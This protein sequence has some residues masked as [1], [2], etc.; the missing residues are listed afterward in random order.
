ML[1]LGA[2]LLFG[3]AQ[4]TRRTGTVSIVQ[5]SVDDSQRGRVLSSVFLLTQIAGG[6]GVTVVGVSAH[7]AGLRA[8]MTVA[9]LVLA[10]VWIVAFGRRGEISDSF[11]A[12][13][14]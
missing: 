12:K 14:G 13:S 8:P 9:A 11:V 6:L 2:M 1:S 3:F 5:S 7:G 4:E 10:V